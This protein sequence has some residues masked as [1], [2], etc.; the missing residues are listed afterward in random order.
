MWYAGVCGAR[1]GAQLP[2]SRLG[3]AGVTYNEHVTAITGGANLLHR[4]NP[5]IQSCKNSVDCEQII[6]SHYGLGKN[7][8]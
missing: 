3:T 8:S 5:S 4:S 6:T 2:N 7:T 1:V